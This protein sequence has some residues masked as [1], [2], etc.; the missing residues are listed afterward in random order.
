MIAHFK[1]VYRSQTH[2][3]IAMI[4][5]AKYVALN[6]R[7]LT[8]SPLIWSCSLEPTCLDEGL[9]MLNITKNQDRRVALAQAV[10]AKPATKRAIELDLMDLSVIN[11]TPAI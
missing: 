3:P 4:A 1:L 2:P 7:A 11:L 9:N 5:A 8:L 6:N 10:N